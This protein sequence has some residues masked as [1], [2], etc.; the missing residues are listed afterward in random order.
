SERLA[1]SAK[2]VEFGLRIT[3]RSRLAL[4]KRRERK[5]AVASPAGRF[6]LFFLGAGQLGTKEPRLL[7]Q[8]L[9][10]LARPR[11]LII[12]VARQHI[13]AN[14]IEKERVEYF[15]AVGIVHEIAEQNV[16]L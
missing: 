12:V 11:K 14:E 15:E 6:F 16:V 9:V 10:G 4:E 2:L 1:L 7:E 8:A 5:V 13:V 3:R